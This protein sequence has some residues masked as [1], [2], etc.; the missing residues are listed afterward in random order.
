MSPQ[1]QPQLS[2]FWFLLSILPTTKNQIDYHEVYSFLSQRNLWSL[3]KVVL[4]MSWIYDKTKGTRFYVRRILIVWS[5]GKK[6]LL[7]INSIIFNKMVQITSIN[8]MIF[9]EKFILCKIIELDL[10][11]I[12]NNWFQKSVVYIQH[13]II[14]VHMQFFFVSFF[15]N[16][17]I[18]SIKLVGFISTKYCLIFGWMEWKI[19]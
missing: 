2:K 4:K 9:Q 18:W 15:A 17:S 13:S 3:I 10:L 19:C 6:I 11:L 14:S 8:K 7:K 12:Y 1:T 16:S 5:N